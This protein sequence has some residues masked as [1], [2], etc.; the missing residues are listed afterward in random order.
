[1]SKP[2]PILVLASLL[3]ITT[4]AEPIKVGMPSP[5]LSRFALEGAIP[6]SFKGKIVLLDFWASWCAPCKASFPALEE[7]SKEYGSRGLIVLGVSVDEK[8]QDMDRFLQKNHVS[9]PIVRDAQH[10]LVSAV[11]VET[12]PSSLLI[13][14][15]GVVRFIHKGFHGDASIKEYRKEI[16]QLLSDIRK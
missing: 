11:A 15:Q 7:L 9:F 5:D 6:E 13:D 1:M 8:K 12:M 10:K 2:R 14:S 3:V 4:L 16:E